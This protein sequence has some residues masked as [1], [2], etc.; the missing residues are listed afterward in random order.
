MLISGP[1]ASTGVFGL[2]HVR[3]ITVGDLRLV[4][5]TVSLHEPRTMIRT[6]YGRLSNLSRDQGVVVMRCRQGQ[7]VSDSVLD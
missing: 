5:A 7:A 4:V 3:P 2:C 1:S 6:G